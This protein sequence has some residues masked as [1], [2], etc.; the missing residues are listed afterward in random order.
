[1]NEPSETIRFYNDHVDEY[2]DS[3]VNMDMKALYTPF[4]QLLP[5]GGCILDAGCGSGR[6][7]KTF[8]EQGYQVTAID[9]SEKMVDAASR[10]TRQP[11][12]QLFLQELDFQN[13]FDGVWSCASVLHVPRGEIDDVLDRFARALQLNGVCYLSF[14]E[15]DGERWQ[16]GRHFTDFTASSI[17]V[18]LGAHRNLAIVRIWTTADVRPGRTERWVNALVRKVKAGGEK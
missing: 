7:T 10:L 9:G 5:K 8:L 2:V 3:T 14:K 15:G 16:D 17:E 1:M 12:R 11:V 13:V 6:D 4:L 18:C